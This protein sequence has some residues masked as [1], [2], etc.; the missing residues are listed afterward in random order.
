MGGARLSTSQSR[1]VYVLCIGRS[2]TFG[3]RYPLIQ[4]MGWG[5]LIAALRIACESAKMV[6]DPESSHER[7]PQDNQGTSPNSKFLAGELPGATDKST[8]RLGGAL[9]VSLLTHGGV[10]LLLVLFAITGAPEAVTKTAEHLKVIWL[11]QPGPG[12]GGGGSPDPAP[13]KKAE[14]PKPKVTP[15]PTPKVEVPKEVPPIPPITIPATSS[16]EQLPG[17]IQGLPT[18]SVL[19]TGGGGGS[20]TGVGGGRGSGIGEGW[21]GGT[22]GGAYR[23]GNGVMSPTLIFEVKP[24]YTSD[25]MRAKIQGV[26]TMEAVVMPDGTVGT[27]QITR[28]LDPTFGLDQEA[29]KTVKK[30]RFRPGTRFGQPVAVLVEIEM[31][32]TLR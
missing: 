6:V 4:P 5:I 29:I 12:G 19:G 10:F 21:G 16:I 31:T 32:F 17:A 9:S 8:G 26:V 11:E 20:G 23:P 24:G 13:I 2:T 15:T 25:A 3:R 14:L 1:V 18:A 27:V 30:W 7:M 28:S 22:G